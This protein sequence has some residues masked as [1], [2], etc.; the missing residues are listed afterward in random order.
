[1]EAHGVRVFLLPVDSASV[2]AFSVWHQ[3]TPFVFLN[4]M[5]SGERG[6]MDAAHKLGHLTLHGHGVPRSRQVELEADRFASAFLMPAKEKPTLK[7]V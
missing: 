4:P 6:R 1:L 3:E 2:D 7:V 5:K